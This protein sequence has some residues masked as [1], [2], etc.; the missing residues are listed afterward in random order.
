MVGRPRI[1]RSCPFKCGKAF[2]ARE[3]REHKPRCVFRRRSSK[4]RTVGSQHS[5]A[6][7]GKSVHLCVECGYF[8]DR[9]SIRGR[10]PLYCS[11]VCSSRANSKTNPSKQGKRETPRIQEGRKSLDAPSR[12]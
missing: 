8:F 2:S 10:K 11:S 6:A 4:Q 9:K 3:M 12:N 7:S 1:I 5:H